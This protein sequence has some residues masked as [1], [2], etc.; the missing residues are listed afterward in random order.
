M[1]VLFWERRDFRVSFSDRERLKSSLGKFFGRYGD[2]I[3][4]CEVPLSK[5][6]HEI[7]GHVEYSV[8]W[9]YSDTLHWSDISL[10]RYL[11]TKPDLITDFD[12]ITL[13]R[14][15]SMGHLQRVRHANR[16]RLLHRIPDPVPYG[17]CICSNFDPIHSWTCHV[18]GPF[19]FRTSLGTSIL[20]G[21]Y[22]RNNVH[23]LILTRWRWSLQ[24]DTQTLRN[25]LLTGY[26]TVNGIDG[27]GWI[28]YGSVEGLWRSDQLLYV[29]W[30]F[31]GHV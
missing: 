3:K 11:V 15:V 17:T 24:N 4:D 21:S 29:C 30:I 12:V 25:D 20:L 6:L 10:N 18:Y 22:S 13:F 26:V 9:M 7:L 23:V 16:G 19:E 14:A 31:N 5:M 2:L 27:V 8:Q 28:D 1:N